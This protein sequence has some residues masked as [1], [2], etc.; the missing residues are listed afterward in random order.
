M[1]PRK[2]TH[3]TGTESERA[4]VVWAEIRGVLEQERERIRDEIRTYPPPIPACD[5]QF[6]DLLERR[7]QV[8]CALARMDEI[9]GAPLSL[10]VCREFLDELVASS[11]LI[12]REDEARFRSY[13]GVGPS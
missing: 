3:R 12:R 1:P 2:D 4:A 6:N 8:T 13:L 11:D 9:A 5:A 10:T 7:E